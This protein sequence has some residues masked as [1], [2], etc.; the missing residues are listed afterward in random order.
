M[1]KP[2]PLL[3]TIIIVFLLSHKTVLG[4]S[5]D[6]TKTK[7]YKHYITWVLPKD[8]SGVTK[9]Y[10]SEV[11][12]NL[13]VITNHSNQEKTEINFDNIKAIKFREKGIVGR[14]VLYG[15]LSG[16]V[17]GGVIGFAM[18]D[19]RPGPVS[20]TAQE[21]AISLGLGLAIP[22]ALLGALAG[23]A[24]ITIPINGNSKN[25]KEKLMKY[26]FVH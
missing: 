26:K 6:Q 11:G 4:Q 19:D 8:K 13:I 5:S 7:D 25:Q 1:R 23:S 21:K 24:K 16:F 2:T 20:F 15:A 18:G 10:L 3:L 22:G 12:D 9:G 17:F 14:G